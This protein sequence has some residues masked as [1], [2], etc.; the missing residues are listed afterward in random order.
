M[1]A[2]CGFSAKSECDQAYREK[3]DA[4]KNNEA[5]ISRP[6]CILAAM[7]TGDFH[8]LPFQRLGEVSLLAFAIPSAS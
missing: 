3:N 2:F 6:V 1:L 5:G 4:D 8:A 7:R